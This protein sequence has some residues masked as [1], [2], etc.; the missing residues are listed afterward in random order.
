M[1][2]NVLIHMYKGKCRLLA[3]QLSHLQKLDVSRQ[4]NCVYTHI[5]IS[6]VYSIIYIYVVP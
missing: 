5:S 6:Y 4:L 3:G 2:E 1:E